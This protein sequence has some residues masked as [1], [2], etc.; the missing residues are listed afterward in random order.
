MEDVAHQYLRHPRKDPSLVAALLPELLRVTALPQLPDGLQQRFYDIRCKYKKSMYREVH[1]LRGSRYILELVP[2][3][4]HREQTNFGD[5]VRLFS[6][7]FGLVIKITEKHGSSA[8]DYAKLMKFVSLGSEFKDIIQVFLFFNKLVF[9]NKSFISLL[10]ENLVKVW[11]TFTQ[12]MWAL[13]MKDPK[14]Q[15]GVLMF[16]RA[17]L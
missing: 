12:V 3:A 15:E 9:Q 16:S 6:H 14:L 7:L 17:D 11:N 8:E 1:P 13:V 10:D 2:Q 5:Q 4:T